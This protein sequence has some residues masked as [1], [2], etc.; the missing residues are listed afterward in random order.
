MKLFLDSTRKIGMFCNLN[1]IFGRHLEY[2]CNGAR[3]IYAGV[4]AGI[5]D[6]FSSG[7]FVMR[8]NRMKVVPLLSRIKYSRLFYEIPLVDSRWNCFVLL[9]NSSAAEMQWNAKTPILSQKL[10]NIDR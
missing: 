3:K 5:K 7:I 2:Q 8:S 10:L 6:D 4:M 9:E 1:K